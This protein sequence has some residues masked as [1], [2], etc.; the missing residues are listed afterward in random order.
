MLRQVAKEDGHLFA[1][2]FLVCL[3]PLDE[4]AA[5][6]G[7]WRHARHVEGDRLR[8]SQGRA[9]P[10]VGVLPVAS[11]GVAGGK[12]NGPPETELLPMAGTRAAAGVLARSRVRGRRKNQPVR[13]DPLGR[14]PGSVSKTFRRT[15]YGNTR[16]SR[17]EAHPRG[18][19]APIRET[20]RPDFADEPFA[21]VR[22]KARSS[23]TRAMR[24]LAI[25]HY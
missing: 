19:W 23:S 8:A 3:A 16:P 24:I 22:C 5:A 17:A 14:E 2:A 10:R 9:P 13:S 6:L 20:D 15:K 7:R 25:F 18:E 1:V 12:G 4:H 21:R 11:R